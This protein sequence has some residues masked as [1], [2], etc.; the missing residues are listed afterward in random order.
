MSL[1]PTVRVYSF[2]TPS[3]SVTEPN[4]T[5]EK[6]NWLVDLGMIDQLLILLCS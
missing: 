5:T 1:F 3:V 2:D 4:Q 6:L